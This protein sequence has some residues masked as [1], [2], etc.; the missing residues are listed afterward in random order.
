MRSVSDVLSFHVQLQEFG[1]H[2]EAEA[3][4]STAKLNAA[5]VIIYVYDSSDTNSFSHI[6]NLRHKH[7][8]SSSTFGYILSTIPCIFVATKADLDL[9][10]QRHEVQP[11]VY[12]RKLELDIPGL[13]AGPLNVS[14]RD[15]QLAELYHR[16][17]GIAVDSRGAVPGGKRA[18]GVLTGLTRGRW[19]MYILFGVV[20]GTGG[21]VFFAR[22]YGYLH[23]V[24]FFG[25]T[26]LDHRAEHGARLGKGAAAAAPSSSKTWANF[27]GKSSAHPEL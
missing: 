14:A 4:R 13:G 11:D 2:N 6:S 24:G 12:C 5:D 23:N 17:V 8:A 10:Q 3:L 18:A 19:W 25:S 20:A 26:G 21:A 16:I 1:S 22:R 9:A 7:S 27:L 15:D